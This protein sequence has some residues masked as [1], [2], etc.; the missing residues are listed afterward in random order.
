M[1]LTLFLILLVLWGLGMLTAFTMGGFLHV[2][3]VIALISI[4]FDFFRRRPLA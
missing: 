3:L 4:V 1:L 2:L